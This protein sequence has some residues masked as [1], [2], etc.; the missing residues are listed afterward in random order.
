MKLPV[1]RRKDGSLRINHRRIKDPFRDTINTWLVNQKL[2]QYVVSL[3]KRGASYRAFLCTY[4]EGA[5]ILQF[6]PYPYGFDVYYI[7]TRNDKEEC[8]RVEGVRLQG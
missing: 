5:N 4:H 8:L 6:E 2:G 3:R 1:Y 7:S